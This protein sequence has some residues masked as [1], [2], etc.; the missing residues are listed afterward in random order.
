MS[1][2]EIR[3]VAVA[4]GRAIA[5]AKVVQ[6]GGRVDATVGGIPTFPG[7]LPSDKISYTVVVDRN[8]AGQISSMIV[9]VFSQVGQIPL[10]QIIDRAISAI[11]AVVRPSS[12]PP[13]DPDNN[14]RVTSARV[15]SVYHGE[16]IGS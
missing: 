6:A 13:F 15:I 16:P 12:P 5:A 3:E 8:F 4:V 9:D 11:D 1:S 7:S 2:A 14:G 10:S